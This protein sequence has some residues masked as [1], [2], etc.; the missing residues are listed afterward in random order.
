MSLIVAFRSAKE[1]TFAVGVKTHKDKTIAFNCLL[2]IMATH[3]T[4][5]ETRHL[6]E[7]P[8]H[9]LKSRLRS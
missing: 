6:D 5:S 9:F 4:S 1:R 3:F 7:P 8:F 2:G